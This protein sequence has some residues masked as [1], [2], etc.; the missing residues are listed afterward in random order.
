MKPCDQSHKSTEATGLSNL[1]PI[2]H[3]N[4]GTWNVRTMH[5]TYKTAQVAAEMTKY[6]FALLGIS[7]TRW[8][9]WT[10]K[11]CYGRELLLFSGHEEDDGPTQKG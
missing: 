11:N 3:I 2:K 1:L 6:K 8:T 7:D 4:M 10:M 5:H 9:D